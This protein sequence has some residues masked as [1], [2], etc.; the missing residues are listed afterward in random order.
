MS[1]SD[2]STDTPLRI[3]DVI[4]GMTVG[5]EHFTEGMI[6]AAAAMTAPSWSA[7]VA[8]GDAF[9]AALRNRDI[10]ST[11]SAR[12]LKTLWLLTAPGVLQSQLPTGREASTAMDEH[13]R[14]VQIML[15]TNLTAT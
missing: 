12:S 15:A 9:N 10:F 5:A 7:T 13:R 2:E 14:Q 1:L 6:Q 3:Q 4:D 8:Q 11:L